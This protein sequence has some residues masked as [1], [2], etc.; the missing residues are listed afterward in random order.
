MKK[1]KK[2]GLKDLVVFPITRAACMHEAGCYHYHHNRSIITVFDVKS[3]NFSFTIV[4]FFSLFLLFW[5]FIVN[6]ISDSNHKQSELDIEPRYIEQYSHLT[7]KYHKMYVQCLIAHFVNWLPFASAFRKI[8]KKNKSN[9]RHLN[10]N[11][12]ESNISKSTHVIEI[13][14]SV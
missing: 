14:R 9:Q 10:E 11:G 3:N 2:Y 7:V 5:L 13:V 1:K 6:S 12:S 4:F 8:G